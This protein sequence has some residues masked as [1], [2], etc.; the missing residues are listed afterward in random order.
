MIS[1]TEEDALGVDMLRIF[2]YFIPLSLYLFIF[3]IFLKLSLST[4]VETEHFH[5]DCDTR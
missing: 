3:F 4:G 5:S 2:N 1:L